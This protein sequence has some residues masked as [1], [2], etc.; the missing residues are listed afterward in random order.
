MENTL[1]CSSCETQLI[2]HPNLY[3]CS[4]CLTQIRCKSCGE[5][6]DK[7]AK[8]CF[9]C[10]TPLNS[11]GVSNAAIN[12]V[13]F[14]QEG[15][16][17]KFR[18]NFTDVV[19]EGLVSTL[20]GLFLGI[21]PT[22]QIPNPFQKHSQDTTKQI[23]K[24]SA[25]PK[26]K[27]E[28]AQVVI[29]EFDDQA[30]LEKVFRKE[31]DRLVLINQRLKHAG[32]RDQAIRI[33]LVALYA[34]SLIDQSHVSR[35]EIY[36]MLKK[37][38]VLDTHF[39]GWLAKCDEVNKHENGELLELSLPGKD[40]ALE[41]LQEF[42][43]PLINKGTVKFSG[44]TSSGRRTK[45]KKNKTEEVSDE[46]G[47]KTNKLRS[48]KTSPVQIIDQL[49]QEGYFSQHRRVPEILKHCKDNKGQTIDANALRMAML[50]KVKNQVIKRE[51]NASDN[52]YEY[53]I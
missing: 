40:A 44:S 22:K 50:R 27:Y 43:D 13:E 23:D 35:N 16:N 42:N 14:E 4:N 21:S 19:G 9:N 8:G 37:A 1:T 49:M 10:G 24:Q 2:L 53:F 32:K 17:K 30:A 7:N 38:S 28:D 45:N 20:N 36:T 11:Q 51:Q 15:E 26:P 39:I 3:F 5:Q 6:L 47:S 48:S 34:Y 33:T 46:T 29:D 52:Q 18:A 25:I 31:D 41:I 12:N